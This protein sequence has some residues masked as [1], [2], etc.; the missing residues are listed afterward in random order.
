M[1]GVVLLLAGDFRQTLPVI[2]KGTMADA[3]KA[4]WKASNLWTYV[5]KL[6]LTTNM[7]VHLQGDLSAGR[8]A[9]EPLTLG[10][11]KVRVDPTSG[12]ISIPENFCNIA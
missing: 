5:H 6:E 2:P 7:R 4:C 8:F 3:L 10:D 9:Q 11:G 1:G 12:L